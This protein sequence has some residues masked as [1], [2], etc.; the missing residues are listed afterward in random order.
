MTCWFMV[1]FSEKKPFHVSTVRLQVGTFCKVICEASV[2]GGSRV[3]EV[4]LYLIFQPVLAREIIT[5]RDRDV[6]LSFLF[7]N[8]SHNLMTQRNKTFSFKFTFLMHQWD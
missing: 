6:F 8:T 5:P 1:S 3:P 7:L 2:E 4:S